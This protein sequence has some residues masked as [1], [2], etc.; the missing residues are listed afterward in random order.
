MIE[1]TNDELHK[2][3]ESRE[4]L[5]IIFIYTPL[6]GTCKLAEKMIRIVEEM[7]PTLPIYSLNVNHAAGFAQT[8]KVKSVP[9]LY[10]FQKGFGTKQIYA[11]H[12]IMNVHQLLKP[13]TIN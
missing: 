13:Y 6:C 4:P 5:T 3:L 11:F 7:L 12:S 1:I 2:K 10:V 8:W 9:A